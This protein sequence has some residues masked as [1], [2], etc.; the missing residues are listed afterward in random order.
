MKPLFML[1]SNGGSNGRLT[2]R[3]VALTMLW[4]VIVLAVSDPIVVRLASR[5]YPEPPYILLD[6][7]SFYGLDRFWQM[8]ESGQKPI[9]FT[10]SSMVFHGVSPHV[11][12]SSIAA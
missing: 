8:T 1:D 9:V 6:L 10:G 7:P 11:F 5:F 2:M 3:K 12:D 4:V